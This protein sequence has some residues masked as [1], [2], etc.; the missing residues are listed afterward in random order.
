MADGPRVLGTQREL[1]RGLEILHRDG[2]RLEERAGRHG[3]PVV[4]V[5]QVARDGHRPAVRCQPQIVAIR[6]H[7]ERILGGAEP[8]RVLGDRFEDRPDIAR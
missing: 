3:R 7:D 5:A 6:K 1:R 2:P 4:R 8:Q